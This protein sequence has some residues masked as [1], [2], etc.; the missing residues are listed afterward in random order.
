MLLAILRI[1]LLECVRALRG[2]GE[3]WRRGVS[4]MLNPANRGELLVVL[5]FCI[6]VSQKRARQSTRRV[7]QGIDDA[8][9]SAGRGQWAK[10]LLPKGSRR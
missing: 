3:S 9:L 5:L 1:C 4:V 10:G 6:G 7:G 2:L 8:A